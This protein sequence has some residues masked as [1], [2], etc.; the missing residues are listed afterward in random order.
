MRFK[1]DVGLSPQ[2]EG[3]GLPLNIGSWRVA[4]GGCGF[5]PPYLCPKNEPAG[6]YVEDVS[7]TMKHKTYDIKASTAEKFVKSVSKRFQKP[8]TIFC[9]R[10]MESEMINYVKA[11]TARGVTPSDDALRAKAREILGVE[12]TSADE[13]AL[14]QKFKVMVGIGRNVSPLASSMP[15]ID[16]ALLAEFDDE[17]GNMDLSG[18]EMPGSISPILDSIPAEVDAITPPIHNTSPRSPHSPSKGPGLAQDYAELY[19]VSAATAS[20]LRRSATAKMASNNGYMWPTQPQSRS[21]LGI[22]P[23]T[24]TSALSFPHTR[25]SSD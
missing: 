11:E 17:I 7:V 13:P 5:S 3:P 14:L 6:A 23:P 2:E 8:A 4:E 16:D 20:P 9:S 21:P 15:P 12:R 19:R 22:S 24:T 25:T 10:E 1:R 18:I